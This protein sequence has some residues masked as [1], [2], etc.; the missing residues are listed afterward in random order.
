[1]G[2]KNALWES[3]DSHV[4]SDIELFHIHVVIAHAARIVKISGRFAF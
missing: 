2:V 3:L 1:M 4:E